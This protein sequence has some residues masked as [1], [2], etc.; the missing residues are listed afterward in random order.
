LRCK[1]FG[2][3]GLDR[4]VPPTLLGDPVLSF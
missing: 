3:I 1:I 2:I 4:G